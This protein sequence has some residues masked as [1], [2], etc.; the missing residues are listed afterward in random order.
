MFVLATR[1]LSC[2][3]SFIQRADAT[4][5]SAASSDQLGFMTQRFAIVEPEIWFTEEALAGW[6]AQAPDDAG[7]QPHYSI[8]PLKQR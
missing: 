3:S 8:S 2:R 4:L 5:P 6:K 1:G 7:R